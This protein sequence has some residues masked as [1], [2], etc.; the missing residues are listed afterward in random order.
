M[1]LINRII[2]CTHIS[3]YIVLLKEIEILFIQ[4]IKANKFFQLIIK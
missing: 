4:R 3:T 2:D 1:E